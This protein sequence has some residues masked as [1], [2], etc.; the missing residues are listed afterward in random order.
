LCNAKSAHPKTTLRGAEFHISI[1][2]TLILDY[3]VYHLFVCSSKS[4]SSKNQAM[5]SSS[6][7]GKPSAEGSDETPTAKDADEALLEICKGM[8]ATLQRLELHLTTRAQA[9]GINA[10]SNA[11]TVYAATNEQ[12]VVYAH[13][14]LP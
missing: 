8:S 10:I 6:L 1:S 14:P 7:L 12:E 3:F 5:E 4:N 9:A 13:D 2:S 11:K